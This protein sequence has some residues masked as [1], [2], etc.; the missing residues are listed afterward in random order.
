LE[1]AKKNINRSNTFWNNIIWSAESKFELLNAKK[2]KRVWRKRGE[3]LKGVCIQST[4]KHGGGNVLVWGCFSKNGVGELVG[5]TG[6]MTG[7]S[8][9]NI[10]KENLQKSAEKMGMTTFVLQQDNDP[11][12]KCRVATEF[13]N[14]N[15]I[16]LLEWPAQSP[17]L[18]PIEHL[19]SILDQ[20][21]RRSYKSKKV[22]F[23]EELR[24]QWELLPKSLLNALVE[25]MLNRLQEVI[26]NKGGATKC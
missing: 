8:Y 26:D 22:T 3:G 13:F 15:N 18:N 7:D 1:F 10:L 23:M 17:D 5:V 4:V 6:I 19:W 16:N 25:S 24:K 9:I 12:H 14:D 20:K 11:K 21:V 2:R